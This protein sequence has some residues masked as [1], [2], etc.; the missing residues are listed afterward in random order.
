MRYNKLKIRQDRGRF[1]QV[2]HMGVTSLSGDKSLIIN[3]T[4]TKKTKQNKTKQ[5]NINMEK[6]VLCVDY[7]YVWL[8]KLLN[9]TNILKWRLSLII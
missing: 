1:W 7:S 4:K 5:K 8:T 9:G 2:K 3:T 6:K